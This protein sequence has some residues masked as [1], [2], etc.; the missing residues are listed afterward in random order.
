M[1]TL[2]LTNSW[3]YTYCLLL[4]RSANLTDQTLLPTPGPLLELEL[5]LEL[6]IPCV[7]YLPLAI[8]IYNHVWI[9][10]HSS[11]KGVTGRRSQEND[12][13]L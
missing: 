3:P 9:L 2:R 5:E 12:E 7:F 4:K 10:S 8:E 6:R 1:A 13:T 11:R